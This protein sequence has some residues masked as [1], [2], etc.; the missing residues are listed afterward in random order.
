MA[1]VD[2]TLSRDILAAV[3]AG[4]EE[5][6]AFTQDLIRLPS[7]RGQ[8]ATAQDFF[9]Q[10]LKARGYQ[11]DRWV[12]DVDDIKHHPGFSPVCVDYSNAINVVGTLRP[13]SE[14]GRSLILNGHMDVVPV[15]PLDMWTA[16]PFEPRREGDW[17]YGRGSG[18]MKAGL[19]INVYAVDALK[20]LGYRPAATLYQQSVVE[21][22]CTGNGALSCLVRGYRADA[23]IITEP[24]DDKLVRA[25][26]GVIWFQ[27]KVRGLPVHV[28]EAGSGQNAIEASL[29]LIAALRG[30]EARWNA[31]KTRHR[32]FEALDH[33]INFNVGKISGGDW[34]S[35]VPAWCTL[36][37]RIAIYP[38]VDPKAAA[39]EIEACVRDA[40]GRHG[41]LANNPPEVVFNGFL[42]EGYALAEGSEAEKTLERAHL[43]SYGSKLES[44]V[45]PGY[46]DGRV[47]VIYADMPCLVYGPYSEAIHG[48]DERVRLSSVKRVTGAVALFIA[49][50]CG[51]ERI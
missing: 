1:P 27:V 47:F 7:L 25:N 40:A 45:T 38:G 23:A 32:H 9:F 8:E 18:D 51:L 2:A 39:R 3:D 37:C 28:R 14:T 17:L 19:A 16:P 41:F 29:A 46:L 26:V 30:L 5:Q 48:F 4:F 31:E 15:G 12:V 36:D 6:I 24:E 22:E 50:W 10:A 43:A 13:K 49:E 42:A 44:F 21:E 20:R 34:A 33:P 35:S 11:M